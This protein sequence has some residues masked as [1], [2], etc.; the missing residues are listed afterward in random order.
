MR[1]REK[2]LYPEGSPD[3]DDPIEAANRYNAEVIPA[4]LKR[5]SLPILLGTYV[6]PFIPSTVPTDQ[7][8]QVGIVH[9]RSRRDM[10]DMAKELSSTGGG[11]HKWASLEETIV[12]P[13][14]SI[15]DF[16]SI[17][18]LVFVLL[19]AIGGSIALLLRPRGGNV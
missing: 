16:V 1:F 19:F 7:W 6:G 13:V 9:Y 3:G 15:V 17:R 12:F 14:G 11:E 5:G 2:A 4:L 18:G 8:D 10:L